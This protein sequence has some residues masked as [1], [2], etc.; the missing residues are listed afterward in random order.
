MLHAARSEQWLLVMPSSTAWL[1]WK[2]SQLLNLLAM[3]IN[4]ADVGSR[5]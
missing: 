4:E 5:V 3:L 1:G 2:T